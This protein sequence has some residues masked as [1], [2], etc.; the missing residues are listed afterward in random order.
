M[1]E[2]KYNNQDEEKNNRLFLLVFCFLSIA[3]TVLAI[4]CLAGVKNSFL[5]KYFIAFAVGTAFL[6]GALLG[7]SIWFTLANKKALSRSAFSIYI[8]LLFLEIV[9]LILQKTGF[10]EVVQ[11]AE[12]LETYLEKAGVWMPIFYLLLQYLQVI[13]LPIPSVVSTVAGV[14]LFGP[15]WTMIYS[16]IAILLGSFT[17]FFIGR[18]LGNRAVAWMVGEE[19]LV[20][21]QKK[22]KGKDNIFLSVMFLLPVFPDDVLCFVAGLSS[23]SI[24]FFSIIILLSRTLAIATTCYSIQLI[25]FNTWWGLTIWGALGLGVAIFFIWIYKNMDKIQKIL[26]RIQRKGKK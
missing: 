22:M 4:V 20:N 8:L 3:C 19:T 21:W 12:N 10:F 16:L 1:E 5:Q 2:K 13:L 26:E 11:N 25:P 14:A 15:F 17:A 18:K 9:W 23:M 7:F 24:K 6:F